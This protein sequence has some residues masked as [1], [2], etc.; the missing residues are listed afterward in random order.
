[1]D[2]IFDLLILDFF[3]CGEFQFDAEFDCITLLEISF[4]HFFNTSLLHAQLAVK[5]VVLKLSS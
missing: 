5:S 2:S 3:V 1:M 4:L